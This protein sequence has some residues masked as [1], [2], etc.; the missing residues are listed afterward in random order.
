M[1]DT[2]MRKR[3]P[4]T[5]PFIT[6][7][8]NRGAAAPMRSE[9]Y[10][11]VISSNEIDNVNV[12]CVFQSYRVH[13]CFEKT[14]QNKT[15]Q[16]KIFAVGWEGR[17]NNDINANPS[18]YLDIITTCYI[19]LCLSLVGGVSLKSMSDVEKPMSSSRTAYL[20][21]RS[22]GL[23]R[24]GVKR[25]VKGCMH[26]ADASVERMSTSAASVAAS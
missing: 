16:E 5:P 11:K 10:S 18:L 8:S 7:H 22:F 24:S 9:A 3:Y 13:S 12:E 4:D 25:I 14:E 26:A 21:A 19:M 15:Q 1:I 2:N 17:H 6:Q 23:S 20:A